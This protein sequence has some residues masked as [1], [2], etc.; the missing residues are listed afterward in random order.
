MRWR[1]P[2]TSLNRADASSQRFLTVH[3]VFR[4]YENA[5]VLELGTPKLQL[6]INKVETDMTKNKQDLKTKAQDRAARVLKNARL[7]KSDSTTEGLRKLDKAMSKEFG[8]NY[9]TKLKPLGIVM[10][11]K[12]K[13]PKKPK[14]PHVTGTGT[15]RCKT[16]VPPSG[17]S[18][19]ADF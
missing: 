18:P 16:L 19:D 11:E 7:K 3:K 12:V 17:C 13:L 6:P 14:I 9:D 4:S 15:L 10:A 8:K 1:T 2:I 5:V